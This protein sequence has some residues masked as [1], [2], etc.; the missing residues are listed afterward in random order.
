MRFAIVAPPELPVPPYN[1]YGGIERGVGQLTLFLA[2][3]GHN[4]TLLAPGDS[5]IAHPNVSVLPITEKSLRAEPLDSGTHARLRQEAVQTAQSHLTRLAHTETIDAINLRW[6]EPQL[7]RFLAKDLGGLSVRRIVSF[8]C[9]LPP[10]PRPGRESE[11]ATSSIIVPGSGVLYT[12]HTESHRRFLL[13]DKHTEPIHVVP[14]GV[15]MSNVA[16]GH[17]PLISSPEVPTLPLLRQLR[18]RGQDYMTIV[19]TI[20]RSK[21]QK[22]AIEIAKQSELPLVIV[23]G[24]NKLEK[25]WPYF[26]EVMQQV[27]QERILYFGEANET[28]KYELMRFATGLVFC[29]GMENPDFSEPFGRV[30]AESLASGTPIVG[31]RMGS[32]CDL[33]EEGKTGIGFDNIQEAAK[34]IGLIRSLDRDYCAQR[35]RETM[36]IER[37][38]NAFVVL[39]SAG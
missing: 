29:S 35:A 25:H 14:Y 8:S 17:E 26:D 24:R 5:Q 7:A 16:I 30:L 12:A 11:V 37:F 23:G 36:G 13:G 27:D 4:V 6:E 19:G 39:A 21:G 1:G 2:E 32:F 38:A 31:Y 10:V 3:S 9:S 34:A 28:E 22:S 15:D 18:E 33:V 20:T